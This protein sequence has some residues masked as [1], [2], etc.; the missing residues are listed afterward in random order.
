[1]RFRYDILNGNSAGVEGN[2]AGI[3][4]TKCQ[5]SLKKTKTT[6]TKKPTKLSKENIK[7]QDGFLL[8]F[9]FG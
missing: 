6:Q 3:E 9:F 4:E 2:G 8:I 1:M 5:H 7:K